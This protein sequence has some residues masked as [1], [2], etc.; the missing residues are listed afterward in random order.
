MK[1]ETKNFSLY[2]DTQY[3]TQVRGVTYLNGQSLA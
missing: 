1:K 3:D 2:K